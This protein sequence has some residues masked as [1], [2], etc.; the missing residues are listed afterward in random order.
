MEIMLMCLALA[1]GIMMGIV[2]LDFNARR[3]DRKQLRERQNEFK[4]ATEA[5]SKTHNI[6]TEQVAMLTEK[7][8]RVDGAVIQQREQVKNAFSA[9][10]SKTRFKR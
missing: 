2:S 9:T 6:L 5:L 8:A 3:Y 10:T 1:C 4:E 7:V